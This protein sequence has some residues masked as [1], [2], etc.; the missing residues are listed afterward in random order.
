MILIL[1]IIGNISCW[2]QNNSTTTSLFDGATLNGWKTVKE[3]NAKFWSVKDSVITGGDGVTR[4]PTNTYLHTTKSFGNF[5][6][7]ALFRLTGDHS[8]GLINSGIQ[9]RSII[10]DDKII[11]YQADI[12]KGYWGDIYDEH[13]RAKLLGG[14]LRTLKHILN[15]DGWNSYIVRCIGNKHVTYINGVK[16]AEYIEKDPNI[17]SKGVIGIQLHSGGNAKVEFKHITIT[18][19]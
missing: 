17:P 19:L 9:Y 2:A 6:F 18:E 10:K 11:G 14:D 5:E 8:T 3:E 16:T 15:E 1:A 12:G 13:R 7:R 4:I